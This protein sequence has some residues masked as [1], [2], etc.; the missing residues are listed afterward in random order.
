MAN[1]IP[2]GASNVSSI[3]APDQHESQEP[4]VD[5]SRYKSP[6][7]QAQSELLTNHSL[8]LKDGKKL[9][10]PETLLSHNSTTQAQKNPINYAR[11]DLWSKTLQRG[12]GSQNVDADESRNNTKQS[13]KTRTL[14]KNMSEDE[15]RQYYRNLN[16]KD[17]LR[18]NPRKPLYT[19]GDAM[20]A[21]AQLSTSL[22][23][24]NTSY[25]ARVDNREMN[26]RIPS[27]IKPLGESVFDYLFGIKDPTSKAQTAEQIKEYEQLNTKRVYADD[28]I[29]IDDVIEGYTAI[30]DDRDAEPYFDAFEYLDNSRGNRE[31]EDSDEFQEGSNNQDVFHESF[32][33]LQDI[34]TSQG[35]P[36]LE[37]TV[38]NSP[39]PTTSNESLKETVQHQ[40]LADDAPVPIFPPSAQQQAEFNVEPCERYDEI[41]GEEAEMFSDCVE[42]IKDKQKTNNE[43]PNENQHSNNFL[44]IQGAEANPVPESYQKAYCEK[45]KKYYDLATDDC[46]DG[47]SDEDTAND[48]HQYKRVKRKFQEFNSNINPADIVQMNIK[49]LDE[50]LT[51][52]EL[53]QFKQL[54]NQPLDDPNNIQASIKRF[55]GISRELV[56]QANSNP[57]LKNVIFDSL[58]AMQ[59]S[60]IQQSDEFRQ[61]YAF[62]WAQ[63]EQSLVN[64]KGFFSHVDVEDFFPISPGK[65]IG[66]FQDISTANQF[67]DI[68]LL[69]SYAAIMNERAMGHDIDMTKLGMLFAH[70][71]IDSAAQLNQPSLNIQA[72]HKA[73]WA[74]LTIQATEGKLFNKLLK[75]ANKQNLSGNTV[76]YQYFCQA[77][78]LNRFN[79]KTK[80]NTGFC[81]FFAMNMILGMEEKNLKSL[82]NSIKTINSFRQL[83]TGDPIK[84]NH[85]VNAMQKLNIDG[86]F[87]RASQLNSFNSFNDFNINLLA[88]MIY[89]SDNAF[90]L[91]IKDQNNGNGHA[92][93]VTKMKVG[94]EIVPV[95]VDA[96][97]GLHPI[98]SKEHLKQAIKQAAAYLPQFN[99]NDD[100]MGYAKLS[101]VEMT[102]DTIEKLKSLVVDNGYSFGELHKKIADLDTEGY[103]YH[104]SENSIWKKLF[105]P[106]KDSTPVSG[107]VDRSAYSNS[108]EKMLHPEALDRLIANA[109]QKLTTLKRDMLSTLS[110]TNVKEKI[111]LGVATAA[112]PNANIPSRNVLDAFVQDQDSKEGVI[113]TDPKRK[114]TTDPDTSSP[115]NTKIP[116]EVDGSL[117]TQDAKTLG[118]SVFDALKKKVNNKNEKVDGITVKSNGD[119]SLKTSTIPTTQKIRQPIFST[120]DDSKSTQIAQSINQDPSEFKNLLA[121]SLGKIDQK[122]MQQVDLEN[123]LLKQQINDFEAEINELISSK[124]EKDKTTYQ[125]DGA[126]KLISDSKITVK[127]TN[128]P[129]KFIDILI[130]DKLK[131]SF[132]DIKAKVSTRAADFS[133]AIGFKFTPSAHPVAV[134]RWTKLAQSTDKSAKLLSLYGFISMVNELDF[135][136][137]KSDLEKAATGLRTVDIIFDNAETGVKAAK[138][139]A[140]QTNLQLDPKFAKIVAKATKSMSSTTK[141]TKVVALAAKGISKMG[142]AAK[143]VPGLAIIGLAADATELGLY[144]D[145]LVNAETDFE[146]EIAGLY[147]GCSATQTSL[148]IAG[149]GVTAAFPLSA[150]LF[151]LASLIIM[152]IQAEAEKHIRS[153]EHANATYRD[154]EKELKALKQL[155]EN[156]EISYDDK[157]NTLTISGKN[158]Y[159]KIVIKE[160]DITMKMEKDI[161]FA[162]DF[163]E[164]IKSTVREYAVPLALKTGLKSCHQNADIN[165]LHPPDLTSKAQEYSPES[166]KTQHCTIKKTWSSYDPS[167]D[168]ECVKN[169]FKI[170]LVHHRNMV[171]DQF[172]PLKKSSKNETL[173]DKN[174]K[175]IV[176]VG[177]PKKLVYQAFKCIQSD[178]EGYSYTPSEC[179]NVEGLKDKLKVNTEVQNS[180]RWSSDAK[181]QYVVAHEDDSRHTHN[182]YNGEARCVATTNSN[183]LW[184]G[185][186]VYPLWAQK[187]CFRAPTNIHLYFEPA[188]YDIYQSNNATKVYHFQPDE[189]ANALSMPD[190][191]NKYTFGV[192]ETVNLPI[193]GSNVDWYNKNVYSINLEANGNYNFN[194]YPGTHLNINSLQ[195]AD[196]KNSTLNLAIH[197][198]DIACS[199]ANEKGKLTIVNNGNGK[200]F[201]ICNETPH[202]NETT[203]IN[204]SNDFADTPTQ[205]LINKA[206]KANHTSSY[207]FSVNSNKLN[208]DSIKLEEVTTFPCP[209]EEK[210]NLDF[211]SNL[212]DFKK[213]IPGFTT[214]GCT[215]KTFD[216]N[217]SQYHREQLNIK[218]NFNGTSQ[219]PNDIYES[220]GWYFTS[221]ENIRDHNYAKQY[222]GA[223]IPKIWR[224]DASEEKKA[225]YQ[226]MV[227]L[228][229]TWSNHEDIPPDLQATFNKGCNVYHF[230]DQTENKHY[231]QYGFTEISE[232]DI[233]TCPENSMPRKVVWGEGFSDNYSCDDI[234]V[235]PVAMTNGNSDGRYA[236][237]LDIDNSL[238]ES[239]T[240]NQKTVFELI[241]E[242]A[243]HAINQLNTPNTPV[244]PTVAPTTSFNATAYSDEMGNLHNTTTSS[245]DLNASNIST[246]ETPSP[247]TSVDIHNATSPSIDLTTSNITATETT[248]MP[249]ETPIPPNYLVDIRNVTATDSNGLPVR[250][251]VFLTND[252]IK[253]NDENGQSSRQQLT[254]VPEDE[255]V[256]ALPQNAC[257]ALTAK[258]KTS[259]DDSQ[260]SARKNE[261]SLR[262]RKCISDASKITSINSELTA[263]ENSPITSANLNE[264]TTIL[265]NM[266]LT[267]IANHPELG[268]FVCKNAEGIIFS[269]EQDLS[270]TNLRAVTDNF[271]SDKKI[272]LDNAGAI[273]NAFDEL[274]MKYGETLFPYFC[275]ERGK[276][277][278]NKPFVY[279]NTQS[280]RPIYIPAIKEGEG[281]PLSKNLVI[282][283]EQSSGLMNRQKVIVQDFDRQKIYEVSSPY[284]M[285]KAELREALTYSFLDRVNNLIYLGIK[286]KQKG[287][288]KKATLPFLNMDDII[289][290]P[291]FATDEQ[292]V[293]T[294]DI[295]SSMQF[296]LDTITLIAGEDG[297]HYKTQNINIVTD[298]KSAQ[299]NPIAVI[300]EKEKEK[301]VTIIFPTTQKV[302]G[303]LVV[304]RPL[305]IQLDDYF[306]RT[307]SSAT[308]PIKPFQNCLYFNGKPINV[309]GLIRNA[310][311]FTIDEN[312]E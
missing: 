215:I 262:Q 276:P 105:P 104:Y 187:N 64:E 4:H 312:K 49:N 239:K 36:T 306:T 291:A 153:K 284:N 127:D 303:K 121:D 152:G 226:R 272:P 148:S 113:T 203:S 67:T 168:N 107:T 275:I 86:F 106:K 139:F 38:N 15:F 214:D 235:L 255:S 24:M 293:T 192:N 103:R 69:R 13:P 310:K 75:E 72:N 201:K 146:K 59:V 123:R 93:A 223:I 286:S 12:W 3:T 241:D 135:D 237:T 220:T 180:K 193:S 198:S 116:L 307:D 190:S 52:N 299:P 197:F 79:S 6:L 228:G 76:S 171:G 167:L 281:E 202:T 74:S 258:I 156:P 42:S 40:L 179:P 161:P 57:V 211:N 31:Y 301:I 55:D 70:L 222:G 61:G 175:H 230:Y 244:T 170:D 274:Q 124:G 48:P 41:E 302:N 256:I 27:D 271:L 289:L 83:I 199:T 51:G 181:N 25:W 132:T 131:K 68:K 84:A 305:H 218:S 45:L 296:K 82:D 251:K 109:K 96:N 95:F 253:S 166:F 231:R 71:D 136:P 158:T 250:V 295:S 204:I 100:A 10:P 63:N 60:F 9:K 141:G 43:D 205:L 173:S 125:F 297:N 290:M 138:F 21:W 277:D 178:A 90:Q 22:I 266:P 209:C 144:S 224:K 212:N 298:D 182:Y 160:D 32:Q 263:G 155:L 149:L 137:R 174:V 34:L 300:V 169:K 265:A 62:Y 261:I 264:F 164:T 88:D 273:Q 110:P 46:H 282:L 227:F 217:N 87:I 279:L 143:A 270:N 30:E 257:Y 184:K 268:L 53:N 18:H 20:Q 278:E 186:A 97:S 311:K 163:I 259:D 246:A 285:N 98:L 56:R 11:A 221:D 101:A 126:D 78:L 213:H 122:Q 112:N 195:K 240:N 189:L 191:K 245:I 236:L 94:K 140:K 210:A 7:S 28:E 308:P 23:N 120:V 37:A 33:R 194:I 8:L 238:T 154:F 58:D 232:S 233:K 183:L 50:S 19:A 92:I 248:P 150:P 14:P 260:A 115:T 229:Y 65:S 225:A 16:L 102:P 252:E 73:K 119:V 207:F 117:A 294:L 66:F 134:K 77:E 234:Q 196:Q 283:S 151:L 130:P 267:H 292:E 35:E 108:Y 200:K 177:H 288:N 47:N 162:I 304:G 54:L 91:S 1:S 2:S 254:I 172:A 157:T 309:E 142:I 243:V 216:L 114:P 165:T 242:K 111:G 147:V 129:A 26:P 280:K 188:T 5:L 145:M 249:T 99:A 80:S 287:D 159:T 118:K 176:V 128:H 29:F 219:L 44:A 206:V 89:A 269:L 85:V 208:R 39:T 133:T 185:A 17:E 81:D 247:S